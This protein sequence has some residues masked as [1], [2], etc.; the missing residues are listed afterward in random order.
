MRVYVPH[1]LASMPQNRPTEKVSQDD[2]PTEPGGLA[3]LDPSF[4]HEVRLVMEQLGVEEIQARRHVTCR[5]QLAARLP[6]S[7]R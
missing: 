7:V 1:L 5:R 6:R 4:E 3:P 2:I